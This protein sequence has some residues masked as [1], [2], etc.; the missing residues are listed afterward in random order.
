MP[1]VIRRTEPADMPSYRAAL[2]EVARER[3][4]IAWFEAP[5][6][7]RLRA[8]VETGIAAGNP[9]FVAIENDTVVGWCDVTRKDRH[10]NAHVGVLGMGIR[11][12]WRGQGVGRNLIEATVEAASAIGLVR[13]ELH[14][15]DDNAAAIALYQRAGFEQEGLQRK[16]A[17]IDGRYIDVMM[18]ARLS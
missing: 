18:M 12:A 2:D 11:R 4:T 6:I 3:S 15:H 5:P 14:V 13:I 17:L 7:E 16:A 9:H 8:F 10:V 1:V